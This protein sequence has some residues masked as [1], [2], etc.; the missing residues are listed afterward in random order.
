MF[1]SWTGLGEEVLSFSEAA[2]NDGISHLYQPE[3]HCAI[4]SFLF[5]YFV[6]PRPRFR[7]AKEQLSGS[8][9]ARLASKMQFR[10]LRHIKIDLG[11]IIDSGVD[12]LK[13]VRHPTVVHAL[14]TFVGL[15]LF[16]LPI[17]V[18]PNL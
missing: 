4:F 11:D 9:E 14:G 8:C 18:K 2:I 7:I 12:P 3:T 1:D 5:Y 13:V 16:L 10:R 6:L 17:T 15:H